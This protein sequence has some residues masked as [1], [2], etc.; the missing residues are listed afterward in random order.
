[1]KKGILVLM[2]LITLKAF[3]FNDGT[4]ECANQEGVPA[5]I[6][7]IKTLSLNGAQVPYVEMNRFYRATM[8]N[9]NQIVESKIKGIATVAKTSYEASEYLILGTLQLEI[10]DGQITGCQK[11]K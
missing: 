9:E 7:V 11:V 1:M 6:Y 2:S 3:A 4:F 8:N 5:N 10:K